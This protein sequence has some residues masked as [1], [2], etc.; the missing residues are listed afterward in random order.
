MDQEENGFSVYQGDDHP[1]NKV[2][3]HFE[4]PSKIA[5]DVK[6]LRNEMKYEK[7]TELVLILSF[8]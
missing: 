4:I 7:R 1:T 3:T 6:N 2:Q 5:E 8:A